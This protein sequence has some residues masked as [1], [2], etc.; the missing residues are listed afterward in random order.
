MTRVQDARRLE[1]GDLLGWDSSVVL[2]PLS[3]PLVNPHPLERRDE[4][5]V[6]LAC[7]AFHRPVLFDQGLNGDR[8]HLLNN[9]VGDY[10]TP[11]RSLED[12]T[13]KSDH[14]SK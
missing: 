11:Q 13:D 9:D 5:F 8:S 4:A 12:S 14:R 1:Q 3:R 2:P 7:W 10:A 6:V